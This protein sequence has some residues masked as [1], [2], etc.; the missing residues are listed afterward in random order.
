MIAKYNAHMPMYFI[1]CISFK[2]KR[3]VILSD[4]WFKTERA[5]KRDRER[6]DYSKVGNW[7]R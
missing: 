7:S 4:I 1:A 5:L 6:V 3:G 2:G